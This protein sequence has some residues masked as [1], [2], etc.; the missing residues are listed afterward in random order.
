MLWEMESLKRFLWAWPFYVVAALVGVVVGYGWN[1][2]K[3][4]GKVG[5]GIVLGVL[6]VTIWLACIYISRGAR[7]LFR[8][9][10]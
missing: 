8:K 10:R 3:I 2:D 9:A 7:A 4:V 5:A 6:I 1:I